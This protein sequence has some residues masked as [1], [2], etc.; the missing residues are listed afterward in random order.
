MLTDDVKLNQA[1][2]PLRVGAA[3]VHMFFRIYSRSEAVR[4]A[5]AWLEAREVIAVFDGARRRPA[6]SFGWSGAR[7]GS[8]SST[9]TGTRASSPREQAWSSR[10][11]PATCAKR[12]SID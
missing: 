4:L 5:P 11:P 8:A 2:H 7:G 10:G 9:T 1:T 12:I 6:T 3:D